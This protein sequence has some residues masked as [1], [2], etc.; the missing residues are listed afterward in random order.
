MALPALLREV[1][2]LAVPP[3]C[4]ACAIP[5][6]GVGDPLCGACRRAL[7]W[8]RGPRCERCALPAH[9]LAACPA[10]GAAWGRAGAP[11]AHSGP[12]REIVR[13]LKFRGALPLAD[14]MAAAMVAGTP[15]GSLAGATVVPVPAHPA[16]RR[17]RGFDHAD[18]LSRAVATRTGLPLRR[19][20]AR[21][22]S[23]VAQ[24]G[25]GRL[26]RLA[27]GRIEVA[28]RGPVPP[29]VLLVDDVHTTGATLQACAAALQS[30]DPSRIAVLT[31]TRALRGSTVR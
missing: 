26:E 7:P 22:G 31:Y 15:R 27:R 1:L 23:A 29:V 8:L 2:A 25:T 10:S 28:A 30:D 17:A 3:A 13:A 20:L 12:A 11:L 14:L 19:C 18:L 6:T 4:A 9:P 24:L 16:H 5:L 21:S